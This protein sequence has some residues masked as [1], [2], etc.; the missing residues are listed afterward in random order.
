MK[1]AL[2]LLISVLSLVGCSRRTTGIEREVMDTVRLE[3]CD[4]L[5]VDRSIVV[6]D[7]VY[8]SDT[9]LIKEVVKTT[10]DSAGKVIRTDTEREK[11]TVSKRD[12]HHYANASQNRQQTSVDKQQETTKER[13]NKVVKEK[14][15]IFQQLKDGVFLLATALFLVVGCWYYFIYSKRSK[16]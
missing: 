12:T 2:L 9:I 13:E 16:D 11:S 3:R 8:S 5:F 4:T 7:T 14:P 6:R 15:P 10:L 1:R